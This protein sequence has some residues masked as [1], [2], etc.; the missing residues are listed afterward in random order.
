MMLNGLFQETLIQ[1]CNHK[2]DTNS[3]SICLATLEFGEVSFN[4]ETI[5]FILQSKETSEIKKFLSQHLIK[6]AK[7]D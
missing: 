3:I 7:Y 5:G 6:D 1:Y 4:Y 2:N